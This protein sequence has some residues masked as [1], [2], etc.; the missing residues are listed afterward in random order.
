MLC[1]VR[2]LSK[3]EDDLAQ[4]GCRCGHKRKGSF[5]GVQILNDTSFL[6]RPSF[7][8][9]A[10]WLASDSAFPGALSCI[11]ITLG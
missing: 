11:S 9:P 4:G 3:Q 2:L 8:L 1:F 10:W 7:C 5:R 6:L